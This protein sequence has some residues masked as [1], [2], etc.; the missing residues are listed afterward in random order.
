MTELEFWTLAGI[1]MLLAVVSF[2]WPMLQRR[3][4]HNDQQ[5][6]ES[7]NKAF[8]QD[9]LQELEEEA[10]EG[11]VT[12]K[13]EMTKELQQSLLDDVPQQRTVNESNSV[14]VWI[15]LVSVVI[16][17][18]LT[19]GIYAVVGGVNDV[20]Q[21]Q[22]TASQLPQLSQRMMADHEDPMTD[23]EMAD[24]TLALRTQ[25]QKT[26]DDGMGWLLLGRIALA[27]RDILTA[28][29]SMTK[30]YGLMPNDT[31]VQLGYAQS[32]MLT[33][34]E[35][36]ALRARELL[37][38]VVRED[39]G[40]LQALSLLAFEAFER[41]AFEEA[42]GAWSTMLALL[43]E[44][45]SRAGMLMRSIQKAEAQLNPNAVGSVS[46][47]ILLKDDIALPAQGVLIVSVHSAD[48]APMP[49]AAKRLPLSEFPVKV[50]LNDS[51][52]M[53]PERLLSSLPEVLIKARIDSD[54]NVMT[55]SGDWYGESQILKLGDQ[56][57]ITIDQQF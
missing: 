34:D 42:K 38:Q 29:G 36:K 5:S 18:A 21:W 55:K 16:F 10:D 40:N 20:K 54:G 56:G 39:H 46:V 19:F 27:N 25:L 30:A 33:G 17:C 2:A 28:E 45:D 6:R 48:G 35:N 32:L 49:I 50:E 41:G 24:M 11:L 51:D 1:L 37:H 57:Q 3:S 23:Q 4:A 22:I 44:G 53:L 14:S 52:S 12:Q 31:D 47:D 15:T 7:L 26:P 13:E 9:R 8:Y 43:P